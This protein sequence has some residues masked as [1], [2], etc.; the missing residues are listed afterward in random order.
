MI[1]NQ[2]PNK[3]NIHKYMKQLNNFRGGILELKSEL[4]KFFK[5]GVALHINTYEESIVL[6][7][8]IVFSYK[9]FDITLFYPLFKV[10]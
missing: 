1:Y 4:Q 6:D 2:I 7:N 10:V 3:R 8:F 5:E 9:Q